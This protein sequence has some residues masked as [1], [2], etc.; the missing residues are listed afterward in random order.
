M[1]IKKHTLKCVIS[2]LMTVVLLCSMVVATAA[3]GAD[4][5]VASTGVNATVFFK[6]TGNWSTV[7][8]YVW[9]QGTST[10]VQAW[11]G[12]AMTLLEDNVY[13]Y[14]VTG[15]YNMIIFNN[16]S[17]TQT[18]DLSIPGDGYIFDFASG[19]WSSYVIP[20]RPTTDDPTDTPTVNPT[21]P[22]GDVTVFC[23]DSAGWGSV[24]VYMWSGSGSSSNASWPGEKM[25]QIED[26]IWQYNASQAWDNVIFNNGSGTQ[27]GDLKFP[28]TGYIYN[29]TTNQWKI[30]DL[31]D[32]RVKEFGSDAKSPQYKGTDITLT[33]E[34]TSTNGAVFYKFSVTLNGK[35]TVL[36][37]FSSNNTCVWTP[38]V[39]GTYTVVYDYR[40]VNGVENQR[41]ATFEINDDS[42]VEAPILKGISPKPGQVKTGSPITFNVNAAGGKVGTNLL[43]YKYTVKDAN[44]VVL[45][46][47]YYTKNAT[48]SYTPSTA[49]TFTVTV[50]VQNA[51][52]DHH[53]RT[54]TYVSG[55]DGPTTPTTPPPTSIGGYLKGDSDADGDVNILD[56]TLIQLHLAQFETD[57]NLE[58][59][60][61]DLNGEVSIL[62][63]TAIQLYLAQLDPNW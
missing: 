27:T 50:T 15:D 28:G 2:L 33:T 42:G 4:K 5:D 34:A 55:N 56:V 37:D 63:A 29:N 52:N 31:S 46:V 53:E 59:A 22:V 21:T 36:A 32:V 35:T 14:D 12:Q 19:E 57:I 7:N 43:F 60:D 1:R 54:F 25:T 16:G 45:N 3:V 49:G 18:A 17:G 23:E 41:T 6:N 10:S 24:Y 48:Y 51:I 38:T 62:D 11:P 13:M 8:A 47:P 26:N 39:A 58:N 40:D 61:A 20:P 30:F 44:G 9:V